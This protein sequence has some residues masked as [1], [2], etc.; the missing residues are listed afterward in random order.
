MVGH[1][2]PVGSAAYNRKL[3]VER[4]CAVRRAL[5]AERYQGDVDAVGMG[6]SEPFRF[7]DPGLYSEGHRHQAHRRVELILRR[8][9]EGG[10]SPSERCEG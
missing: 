1:T 3:S 10:P 7:D 2:D 6:E 9:G 5:L 4:A 8:T